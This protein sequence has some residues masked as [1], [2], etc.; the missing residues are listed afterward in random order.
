MVR[1]KEG[2]AP[3]RTIILPASKRVL[4]P[5]PGINKKEG[6]RQPRYAPADHRAPL[7]TGISQSSTENHL[8]AREPF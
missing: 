4:E 2:S 8:S 5:G 6:D 3:R 7:P 1:D